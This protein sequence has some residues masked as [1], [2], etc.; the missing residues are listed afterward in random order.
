[1]RTRIGSAALGALALVVTSCTD[2]GAANPLAPGALPL[3]AVASVDTDV[4]ISQV[5]GG[6][7]N[8]GATYKRDFIE[9]YNAGPTAVSLAGWTVQYASATGTSWAKTDLTGSIAPGGYYLIQ[10]AAGTG[11]T[12]DLPTPEASGSIAMSG[13]AGKV[14][15]VKSAALLTGTG[16]PLASNAVVIDFVGYGT[17]ANCAEGGAPTANLANA[18]AA[19]RAAGGAT[20]TD[21]N[22]ADFAV[23]APEPR[24]ASAGAPS[25]VGTVPATAATGVA[26]A[27]NVE[28]TFSK[29]VALAD[30]WFAIA[31]TVSGAKTATVTGGPTAYALDPDADFAPGESCTVTVA[32]GKVADQGTPPRPLAADYSWSFSTVAGGDVCTQPFIPA[33]AIQGSG[34]TSPLTIGT[35]VTTQ[36]VVVAD[37]EGPAPALRGFYLQDAAGDGDAS[38]SD[39]VFVFNGTNANAV[40]LGD[41]VRVS[42]T[43]SEFAQQT[44]LSAAG[45]PTSCGTGTVAPVDVT[46]PLA[47]ADYLERLEGMLVRLPQKLYVTEHFELGRFGEVVLSAGAR[48]PQP[49][50]IAAPGTAA[51]AQQAANDL[52]KIVLDDT[53][54]AQNVDPIIF[55]GGGNPLSAA[56]TLRGGDAA[57]GIV[58]VLSG[59]VAGGTAYRVRPVNTLGG[60]LPV[61]DAANPRPTAPPQV[62][63]TL[64]V[65]AL[66][67]LNYFNNFGN[68]CTGGVGG[69]STECRGA[70]NATEFAR[71]WPKTVAAI[72][73]IDAD[74]VGINEVENDGYGPTS[75]I[76]DIVAKLNSET[77]AGTYAFIDADAA[78][79]QTNALGT[80]AIK[81]GLIYKPARVKPVGT[82]AAL[83]TV[84]FV[85]GG[86]GAP[87]GRPALAQAFEQTNRAR[88]VVTVNHFKSKGS[89]C[90]VPDAGD[91]QGNCNAVRTNAARELLSWL[92]ADPT[93]TGDPDV[94]IMGDLNSYAKEDP[95]TALTSGGFTNLI[96]SKL[97]ANAYSYVFD[98]QWGYL[99]HALASAS[100]T[101]LVTGVADWHIN[102]DEPA[103][104]D[105]NTNFKTAGQ[106]TSLY[107]ADPFRVADHDPV[108]VGL[109]LPAPPNQAPTARAGG[110][111]KGTE[112]GSVSFTGATASDPE[113]EALTYAWSFGDGATGTGLAPS[114]V[115]AQ[116]GSY[117][118]ELVATDARGLSSVAATA[119]VQVDNVAPAVGAFAGASGLLP[120]ETY[121]SS[122]TFA[123]PGADAWS[124]TVDYGDASGA[125]PL[126]LSGKS[127]SLSHRYAA[128]GSFTVTVAVTDDDASG[129]RT[130]TVGVIT[131]GAALDNALGLIDGLVKSKRLSAGNATALRAKLAAA[132]ASAN[133]NDPAAALVELRSLVAELDALVANRRLTSADAAPLRAYAL[134]IIASLSR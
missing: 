89:A 133:R 49:T 95:I 20:D 12:L 78:T 65:A 26:L 91:G 18:T 66:N 73:A 81:V 8:T 24:N 59:A 27:A 39:A 129:T 41:V 57:T 105:Y 46:L 64:K 9:L 97:G 40:K 76:A 111:Y 85:N 43:V 21:N 92:A 83:N 25:V 86:D 17:T 107:S 5:Y 104:L 42:G 67:V 6:G 58:G 61:F 109:D 130:A 7:G 54:N 34:A 45:A 100:L 80:D 124:A 10:Q 90:A 94:L 30:G 4:N 48:L 106:V 36:G 37:Y 84:A 123:D 32:A 33:F 117:T 79:G 101:P 60:G 52:N 62:G 35:S 119:T 70:D 121:T 87:R 71:Q 113:G 15:L 128:A 118:A 55:G 115:Y 93:T 88:F 23:V 132:K 53:L 122:G 99:D 120:G 56:N 125:A 114:H 77:A 112:G 11:G 19:V 14:A 75:A 116:D 102:A 134:R 68:T 72:R 28:V 1:M 22:A 3:T 47:S 108:L 126:A 98:G 44:Q 74:V 51:L 82:T 127:F 103:V 31:C 110:P 96:E 38:T 29:P 13:T 50:S 69:R 2:K 16:C 131:I 63:G